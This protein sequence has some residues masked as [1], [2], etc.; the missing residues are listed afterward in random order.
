MLFWLR[1]WFDFPFYVTKFLVRK[2]E[3]K[4]MMSASNKRRKENEF[5]AILREC[6]HVSHR[7]SSSFENCVEFSCWCLVLVVRGEK[8][9]FGSMRLQ[10]NITA[11]LS[12]FF[13]LLPL[14]CCFC[15]CYCCHL[16]NAK[17]FSSNNSTRFPFTLFSKPCI[18]ASFLPA[19]LLLSLL[20]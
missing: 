8:K 3:S 9:I 10:V 11:S 5:D 20:L 19:P 16:T 4:T 17:C 7:L 13:L 18:E 14:L 15:S 1:I 12:S 6:T 2:S